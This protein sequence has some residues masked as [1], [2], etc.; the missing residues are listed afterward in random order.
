MERTGTKCEIGVAMATRF[1]MAKTQ[2]DTCVYATTLTES[3]L[4]N[5]KWVIRSLKTNG[6]FSPKR[7]QNIHKITRRT[8]TIWGWRPSR[9]RHGQVFEKNGVPLELTVNNGLNGETRGRAR[10]SLGVE[11]LYRHLLAKRER[12]AISRTS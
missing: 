6:R 12:V 7:F 4:P 5:F 11:R 8:K 2:A 10:G 1:S 3:R 9:Q